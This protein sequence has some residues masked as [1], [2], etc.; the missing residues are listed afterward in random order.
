MA[1]VHFLKA[2]PF[3]VLIIICSLHDSVK[4]DTYYNINGRDIK[5]AC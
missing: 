4:L 5:R 3:T 2:V 1:F